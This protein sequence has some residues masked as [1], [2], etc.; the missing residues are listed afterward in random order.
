VRARAAAILA[1]LVLAATAIPVAQA[2]PA[3]AA[4]GAAT[5][6][7]SRTAETA[8]REVR[9][10]ALYA[11]GHYEEAVTLFAD[12]FAATLHPTYLRNI[13]RCYQNLGQAQSAI[14]SFRDYLRKARNISDKERKEIGGYIAEMEALEARQAQ[15]TPAEKKPESVVESDKPA[16][17]SPPLPAAAPVAL[18][19]PA[20]VVSLSTSPAAAVA[21]PP[22]SHAWLYGTI[23]AVVVAGAVGAFFVL[24]P[25]DADPACAAPRVCQ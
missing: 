7:R 15:A 8:R 22:R 20:P 4:R 14:R 10:R 24:R 1:F 9:A 3:G 12:L 16:A 2:A 6:T 19:D 18:A 23:A 17:V 11:E 5:P 13:G 21:E 25:H